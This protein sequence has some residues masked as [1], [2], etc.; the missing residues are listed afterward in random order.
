VDFLIL[1]QP[2]PELRC[3]IEQVSCC[4]NL[5]L[6][7]LQLRCCF[8]LPLLLHC[9]WS[10]WCELFS[11]ILDILL[12]LINCLRN[13]IN[14]FCCCD[15]LTLCGLWNLLISSCHFLLQSFYVLPFLLGIRFSLLIYYFGPLLC[16][17]LQ[18]VKSL[19]VRD[20]TSW[21]TLTCNLCSALDGILVNTIWIWLK[22][23]KGVCPTIS[24]MRS[25][26][27]F[28]WNVTCGCIIAWTDSHSSSCT[29]PSICGVDGLI[30]LLFVVMALPR[31]T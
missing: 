19:L 5:L 7:L 6:Y 18:F 16:C 31:S 12:V 27:G 25:I 21:F 26:L 9:W 10:S 1:L 23:F 29:L 28:M 14:I 24:S 20:C 13:P 8:L 11:K 3:F 2:G 4:A 17:L 30:P 22:S 15:Y